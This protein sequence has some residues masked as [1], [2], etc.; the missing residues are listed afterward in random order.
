ME[1]K[2]EK[3]RKDTVKKKKKKV[4]VFVCILFI[5]V[6]FLYDKI[7]RIKKNLRF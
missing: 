7:A 6:F 2:K 4:Y 5:N 3:K 1:A